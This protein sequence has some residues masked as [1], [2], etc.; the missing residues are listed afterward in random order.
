MVDLTAAKWTKAS[1]MQTTMLICKHTTSKTN[2]SADFG[3][4]LASCRNRK[5]QI[6][7][8]FNFLYGF[9]RSFNCVV[10]LR[11]IVSFPL[12]KTSVD[13]TFVRH[14]LS[15]PIN[16]IDF[17]RLFG[18]WLKMVQIWRRQTDTDTPV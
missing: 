16:F 13:V 9:M 6:L 8:G 3:G 15:G 2:P 1:N 18:S 11:R 5:A 17:F 10:Q 12:I 14:L 7:E 4:G